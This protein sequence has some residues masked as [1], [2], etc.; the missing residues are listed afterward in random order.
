MATL[1]IIFSEKL[2]K[3]YIGACTDLQRRLYEHS[4]GH[5]KFTSKGIPWKLVYHENFPDLPSAKKKERHLKKMKSRIYLE[6]LI[7]SAQ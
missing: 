2:D 6:K 5:S 3:Y 1:Y 7:A 4:I